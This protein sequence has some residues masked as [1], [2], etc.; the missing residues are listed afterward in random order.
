MMNMRDNPTDATV[1]VQGRIIEEV[2]RAGVLGGTL[3]S[4][5]DRFEQAPD[6][7]R[8]ALQELVAARWIAVQ[9][10][11]RGYLAIRMERRTG[12]A[13]HRGWNRRRFQPGAWRL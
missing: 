5:A 6:S 12:A 7:I 1:A 9:T 2:E 8:Q 11:P 13:E 10:Q 4:L 3:Q